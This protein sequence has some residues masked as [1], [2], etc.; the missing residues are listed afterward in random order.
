MSKRHVST[1]YKFLSVVGACKQQQHSTDR[2][3]IQMHLETDFSKYFPKRANFLTIHINAL[4][5]RSLNLI[6]K[7]SYSRHRLSFKVKWCNKNKQRKSYKCYS[8]SAENP[9]ENIYI[10]MSTLYNRQV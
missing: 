2:E 8:C 7:K 3:G 4:I 10:S 6:H 5:A 1:K 9:H